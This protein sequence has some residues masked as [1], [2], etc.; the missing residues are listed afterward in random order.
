M[1]KLLILVLFL[2]N[3]TNKLSSTEKP[4]S[5]QDSVKQAS[6]VE[7]DK[8]FIIGNRKTKEKIIKRE[9]DIQEGDMVIPD[10]LNA[11]LEKDKNKILNTNLFLS[12]NYN[13]IELSPE[14]I[15][16]IIRVSERWYLFPIPIFEL[17]DRNFN[18]WWVNQN[19]DLSRVEY[20]IKLYNYNTRGMNET[21][22]LIAQFG[23]TK[24]FQLSYSFPYIDKA[25]KIGLN[26]VGSYAENNN[27]NYLTI[28]HKQKDLDELNSTRWLRNV[29]R[30]GFDVTYR[31]SFYNFH[32]ISLDYLDNNIRDTIAQL[33]PTYFL[34]GRNRQR[35]FQLDYSFRRDLRDNNAYPLDG[36]LVT[37][38]ASKLGLGIFNDIDQLEFSGSYSKYLDLG[39]NYYLSGMVGGK[40]SFPEIQPYNNNNSIGFEPFVLRGYELYVIEGQ[41]YLINKLT[42]KKLLFSKKQQLHDFIPIKQFQTFPI[43]LYLKTYFDSGY[44]WNTW[45]FPENANNRFT[46]EFIY[47]GGVGLDLV[48]FYDLV[49][50]FEYSYNKAKESGLVIGLMSEF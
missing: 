36:F 18:E 45:S 2:G 13:V 23:F 29:K 7:I 42:F 11:M 10:E 47:G 16:I 41:S 33:N 38:N 31:K 28:D 9:M 40:T 14:K 50:R 22:K 48:T 35:F 4:F 49:I 21:L 12:V 5:E 3:Q 32:E 24:R 17:A 39:K 19:R 34:D 46:N 8:I 6:L 20:G 37:A 43:A 27:F 25:Q 1:I 26:L 15:D 44:I 30:F